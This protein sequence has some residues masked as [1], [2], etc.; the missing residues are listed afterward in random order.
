MALSFATVVMLYVTVF[1]LL[2]TD[3]SGFALAS[4]F[5]F[6]AVLRVSVSSNWVVLASIAGASVLAGSLAVFPDNFPYPYPSIQSVV[7][8]VPNMM[9][10]G[11]LGSVSLLVVEVAIWLVVPGGVARK[12]PSVDDSSAAA[13]RKLVRFQFTL[14]ALMVAVLLVSLPLSWL[15]FMRARIQQQQELLVP[16]ERFHPDTYWHRG[17]VT[18]LLFPLSSPVDD[19]DLAHVARFTELRQLRLWGCAKVT[20]AALVDI[21]KLTDLYRLSIA[22]TQ[23]TPDGVEELKKTLPN[24]DVLY[25]PDSQLVGSPRPV[26]TVWPAFPAL[27]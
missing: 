9:A 3:H 6:V 13:D 24:C 11:V 26:G 1:T 17:Y 12:E 23:I 16:I 18:K 21:S 20:D 8:I 27:P 7:P 14:R 22:G 25:W 15:R 19:D 2:W 5:A 4:W 10:G